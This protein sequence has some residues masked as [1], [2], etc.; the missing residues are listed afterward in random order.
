M[1]EGLEC[2]V[3]GG[4]EVWRKAWSVECMGELRCGGPEVGLECAVYGV[5]VC[6]FNGVVDVIS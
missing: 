5:P 3:S 1:E 4:L 6:S 2:G